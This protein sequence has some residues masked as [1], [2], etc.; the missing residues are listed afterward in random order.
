MAAPAQDVHS[1]PAAPTLATRIHRSGRAAPPSQ[2][3]VHARA[4]AQPTYSI[5]EPCTARPVDVD[6]AHG[7]R[8]RVGGRRQQRH[9]TRVPT[10]QSATPT[11]TAGGV[12]RPVGRWTVAVGLT[13]ASGHQCAWQRRHGLASGSLPGARS[14]GVVCQYGPGR[15]PAHYCA[16]LRASTTIAGASRGHEGHTRP[17]RPC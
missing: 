16:V 7:A 11:P 4:T 6:D 1:H 5:D 10:P 2:V 3:H 15:T 12:A 9:I 17:P 8:G 13:T 14:A